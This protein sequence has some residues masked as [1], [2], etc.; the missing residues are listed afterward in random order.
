MPCLIQLLA[1]A[2]IFHSKIYK[3]PQA[4]KMKMEGIRLQKTRTPTNHLQPLER[5]EE[6]DRNQRSSIKIYLLIFL[7]K[8]FFQSVEFPFDVYVY[9]NSK[10]VKFIAYKLFYIVLHTP[11]NHL[12]FLTQKLF[13]EVHG[14]KI[15]KQFLC[16]KHYS[17]KKIFKCLRP[18][19]GIKCPSISF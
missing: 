14:K 6:K 2:K 3:D 10:G 8:S 5:G 16:N 17:L 4:S 12:H 7:C 11:Q 9:D 1:S 18:F 13:L 15:F 19:L